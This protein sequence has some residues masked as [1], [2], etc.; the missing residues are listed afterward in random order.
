[1]ADI[2]YTVKRGDTLW[3][4]AKDYL[5][6][7]GVSTTQE[8]VNKLVELNHITDPNYI[9]VGQKLKITGTPDTVKA[10]TTSKVKITVC[11]L[12][13]DTTRTVYATWQFD[14]D[15]LKEYEV[16]WQYYTANKKWFDGSTSTTT[17]RQSVYTAPQNAL[18]VRVRVKPY[19]TT[20]TKTVKK[21][22]KEVSYWTG[23][24][25]S[26][27]TYKFSSNPPTAPSSAPTVSIEKY[28]LTASVDNL[29]V[30]GTDIQ[31]NIV[32]DD[33]KTFKT[34][35]VP[36]TKLSAAY[37]C[38][39]D[40]GS[41]YKVR[42]RAHRDGLYSDWTDYSSSVATVPAAPGG[43]TVCRA[44]SETSVYLE[45]QAVSS[46]KTYELQYATK[47]E[48][49]EG[50]DALQSDS[51]IETTKYEKTG[52]DSGEEYFFR[53]RAVNDKGES[54]W[55]AI[56]SVVIG[57]DP[58]APTTWS[59]S[60]TVI[61]GEPLNLY[62]IHNSEDG[63]SQTV[64]ELEIT[65]DNTKT[66]YTIENL[67]DEDEKD[68]TS[69]YTVDTSSYI[70]GTKL[71]WRVR[72][73]GV[74]RVYGD[75]SVL[76]TV[77]IYAPV[78]LDLK[79]LD[80]DGEYIDVVESFPIRV[81]A[82]AGPK[83]QAP[84]GYYLE[85]ISNETYET[86][87]G[88]GNAK[89]VSAGDPIYSEYFDITSSLD[90]VLSAG[91]IDLENNVNYSISCRVSM[92]S[93]LTADESVDFT[94][95]WEDRE[96]E[97]NA[98]IIIDEETYIAY[99]RPFCE[100]ENGDCIPN[101]TLSVY[102]REFDGSFAEIA[103]GI[104]NLIE[105]ECETLNETEL[106]FTSGAALD[107]AIP[108]LIE[109][110]EYHVYWNGSE[111]ISIAK[112]VDND[113]IAVVYVGN[114]MIDTLGLFEDPTDTDEPFLIASMYNEDGA[115]V[116]EYTKFQNASDTDE[117]VMVQIITNTSVNNTFVTDP[118]PSLDYARYRIVA[119]DQIT[120]SVSYCDLP[121][122]PVGG[123]S[124]V[125][126]WDE[127]W[128]SF[129][130][131]HGDGTSI[132]DDSDQPNWAGSML[133]LPYNIDVSESNELDVE[134]VEYIGREHPVTYYGTQIGTTAEWSMEIEKSDADTLYGLR[135]LARW[136]GD[137]YVREPSGTGY[138]ANVSISMKQTHCA[139]TIPVSISL[140]RVEG[141]I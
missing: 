2:T 121:G 34:V 63:S 47:V 43:I 128:S 55:T 18:Q 93:G 110:Q 24:W 115:T 37:T 36:I 56:K 98:S 31:F 23:A 127:E 58:E 109:G 48:Y 91:D 73:A 27:K 76:R 26:Y 100:D 59:S 90:V 96:Y 5:S 131:Y 137:V 60:S 139:L 15:H 86:V 71:Q 114:E 32:K 6:V 140:V 46:A 108:P 111:Y 57:S 17:S 35:T 77:D 135:R 101:V 124:V 102:R 113:G 84:I 138:W 14:K 44:N 10:N 89:I 22:E 82:L 39:V 75:W 19:S 116:D 80:N 21:K 9:V 83:T 50:S 25:C 79:L 29:N 134:L 3:E 61:V 53:V 122:Y 119:I 12:Q 72:T 65:V 41:E 20:Y 141:G 70:E 105:N 81:T 33:T 30:N 51:G 120:G 62:W 16:R 129:D 64:A 87:D 117:T 133:K 49:F 66:T 4:I 104:E 99:I 42:C 106:T 8:G 67:R 92:D 107:V 112:A 85:V 52:L 69:S 54:G 136:M 130:V 68:K 11:G 88:V 118:H 97:P 7:L 126:Q 123:D 28:T 40:A 94:V 103:T 95:A 74:T 45:W 38:V 132:T 125:L 1:M 78:T 13:A